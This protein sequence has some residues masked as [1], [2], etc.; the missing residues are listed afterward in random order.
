MS[1]VQLS[2]QGREGWSRQRGEPRQTPSCGMGEPTLFQ[3]K[4]NVLMKPHLQYLA[5][6]TFPGTVISETD[7]SA[8][9]LDSHGCFPGG[10]CPELP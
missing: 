9:P 5:R 10:R 3:L 4:L 6:L 2:R 8:K 7:F 1:R